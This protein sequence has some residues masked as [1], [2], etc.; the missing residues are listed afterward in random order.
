MAMENWSIAQHC[1]TLRYTSNCNSVYRPQLWRFRQGDY[2][3]LQFQAPTSFDV[4]MGCTIL[5]VLP[6]GLLLCGDKDG[7]KCSEH[8]KNYTTCYLFIEGIVYHKHAVM[9]E[10][11]TCI[12]CGE[13]K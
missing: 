5:R 13:K 4:W 11:P 12:V 7:K 2:V 6:S 1:D 3:Y 10:C 9:L 8:S